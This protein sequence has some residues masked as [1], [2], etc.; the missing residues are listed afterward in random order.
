MKWTED[1]RRVLLERYA[2]EDN[3]S[4]AAEF[5][6]TARAV[7]GQARRLGLHKS[8]E[9]ESKLYRRIAVES[10]SAARLN[11]PEAIEKRKRTLVKQYRTDKARIMFGLEQKT[12]RHIRIESRERLLQ[13][14]RLRRLGYVVDERALVAYW[15]EKTHRAT[16]L[17]KLKRGEQKG[18]MKCFYDF[19]ELKEKL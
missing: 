15:T 19:A 18:S 10:G 1:Q 7:R 11:T 6:V 3:E 9:Y 5:G 4:L 2:N 8:M 12:K 16:R 17:E 13:R 14:N